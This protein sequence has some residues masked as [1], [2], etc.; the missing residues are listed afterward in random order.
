MSVGLSTA[1]TTAL[2]S[3]NVNQQQLAAL[4]NNI[5]NANTAGYSRQVA[6][7]EAVFLDGQGAGVS[8]Q[9][10]TRQVDQSL[11]NAV[12]QQN[13]TVGQ[14]GVISSYNSQIQILIG[15]PGNNN[16]LD[17]TVSSFFNG[18]QALA[19]TPQNTALQQAAVNS[20]VTLATQIQ[21]TAQGLQ[22]L[23]FQAET[24]I[25]GA[26]TNINNDLNTLA[27]LNQN[28]S[29]STLQG[30]SVSGLEDQRD[31]ALNDLAQYLNISTFTNSNGMVN[32]STSNGAVLLDG[33]T[34]YQLSYKAAPSVSTFVNGG[35]VSPL[36]LFRT[37][38]DGNPT[39]PPTLLSSGGV[40]SQV[41]TTLTSGKL[42]GLLEMRDQQLPDLMD[43]LDTLSATLR[44]QVNQ[45]ENSGSGFPGANSLTGERPVNADTTSQWAGSVRIAV[46][47]SSGQPVASPYADEINGMPPLN[48]DLSSLNTGNGVGN[49]SVQGII[50][51]INQ[52]YGPQQNKVEL[53]NL[54]NIQLVSDTPA[55]PG[56]P[57]GINFDLNLN[58][59]SANPASIYVTG[60]SVQ[61]STGANT[62]ST[63]S[64]VDI[65]INSYTTSMGSPV[66]QVNTA[67]SSAGLTVGEQ[68]YL[69]SPGAAIDNI[70]ANNLTGFFT[71]TGVNAS[72]FTID[73]GA[74]A[75]AGTTTAPTGTA[76]VT[77]PYATVPSGQNGRTVANGLFPP[78]SAVIPPR[79]IIPLRS[80]SLSTMAAV[81]LPPY[82]KLPIWSPTTI[83][84]RLII[85]MRRNRPMAMELLWPLR[86]GRPLRPPCWLTPMVMSCLKIPMAITLI[87]RTDFWKS[88]RPEAPMAL[89]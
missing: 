41:T 24:D 54:N 73:A 71:I 19:Q 88:R 64:P 8:I 40:T 86:A 84:A 33:A 29:I 11:I 81:I 80:M 65:G 58:N 23:Q 26:V 38:R 20:G 3:L 61:P 16:S 82:R 44:D 27:T 48:L 43:Q 52:Y 9:D 37:D 15:Q 63:A 31:S 12:Q 60:V 7:Q 18:L 85:I 75:L 32:V 2:S 10:I 45:I 5:A 47:N 72:G 22:G 55:L 49:P 46:L 25:N 28:I 79:L 53:G 4:S 87:R 66:V 17:S 21:Q 35:T 59:I 50:D 67:G 78:P 42:A 39:G 83:R 56:A 51:A 68:V 36:E 14:T 34:P 77:P 69:S 13:S 70:P 57:P 6:N 89:S 1:L 62:T 74:T 30:Q 76:T